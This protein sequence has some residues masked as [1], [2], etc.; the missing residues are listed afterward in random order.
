MSFSNFFI[1]PIFVETFSV[2]VIVELIH[3]MIDSI[4]SRKISLGSLVGDGGMPSRHTALIVALTT[5]IGFV[6]GITSTV[7]YLGLII[8]FIVMKDAVGARRHIDVLRNTVGKIIDK[9]KLNIKNLELPSGH[10]IP[11][12]MVSMVLSIIIVT[13]IH[14]SFFM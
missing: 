7:F 10:T 12:V 3:L 2:F 1:N 6:E 9:Q 5:S 11:Q 4:K 13:L 8:S 14:F